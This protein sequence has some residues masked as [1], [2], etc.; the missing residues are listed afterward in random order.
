MPPIIPGHCIMPSTPTPPFIVIPTPIGFIAIPIIGCLIIWRCP[1]RS[2]V[3]LSIA[4][5]PDTEEVVP[6]ARPP[7]LIPRFDIT[8][9]A[10]QR[11]VQHHAL[12]EVVSSVA[13][14][15][16]SNHLVLAG[17]LD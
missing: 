17:I 2:K 8:P 4:S 9:H 7:P 10:D 6:L 12:T 5:G 1:T 15:S 11:T 14:V 13:Y 3:A 16:G